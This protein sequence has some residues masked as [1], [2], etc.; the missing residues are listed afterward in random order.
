M[1]L[2]HRISSRLRFLSYRREWG[3]STPSTGSES[4]TKHRSLFRLYRE[5]FQ[6]LEGHWLT[7]VFALIM[8]SVATLLKLVPPAATKLVIDNVLLGKPL[9]SGL[10]SRLHLPGTPKGRLIALVISVLVISVVGSVVSLWG[11]WRATL[12][13]KK[14]QV[15]VRRRVFDHA[16]RLPLHR[17]YQLKSGGVASLLREDAGGVG[18]LIF[19][20]I[21][22]PWRA[23]VQLVGGLIILLWVDWRLLS[24]A[25]LL[26]PL[27]Y[28]GNR[29]WNRRLRPLYRD[30]RKQRQDIDAQATE[31]F[32]G[33]RVVRAFGR[34]RRESARFVGEN[35]FMT[36]QELYAWQWSRGVELLWDL[37]LPASSGAL[38]LY[39]GL[40]VI[41]GRLTLG[42]L[43]MFL[44][45]L[46]MLLEPLAVLA[47]SVTQLQS[48]LSG[49][50]RV[51]D[52]LAEPREMPAHEGSLK[53]SKRVVQ[54]RVTFEGVDFAY[55]KTD[56]MVLRNINIDVE[57]GE[58]IAL[59]GR[60]GSGKT[61][62]CNLIARFYD[63]VA[64]VVRLDG[65]DLRDIDVESY[66]RLFGI[67][68][69][70]VFLFDGTVAENIAYADRR[71]T[72]ARVE[73][74]ARVANV[75]EFIE[76]L[77][78]GYDTRIGERGFRLSGGQR[79][80]LAIARAILADPP[81]FILDE[82]TS[83]LDSH[84]ERLIQEALAT[85]LQGRTSFVIAH[86]LST[87]RSADRIFVL[88]N[89]AIVETGTHAELMAESLRYRE[90][91]ELQRLEHGD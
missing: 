54:G 8:L 23:L 76:R 78:D 30:A 66:R 84:S 59:V 7:I 85:L 38:M 41:D 57:P 55:P 70:D 90:M 19:S 17:V 81:I 58:V 10:D 15:A 86:R 75:A 68:E 26:G 65:Q 61:T 71:A 62:L 77:P 72:R 31:A 46:T 9:P 67:V 28:L 24:A 18:E 74:A 89:G 11:R 56:A 36:R 73:E 82:A 20:M 29:L 49:F 42:D 45:Y 33:M 39:G 3:R 88:E 16:V 79:Q 80:R 83:N 47:T 63:P 60:S 52:L 51:L 64:G 4:T 43:M 6:F 40:R 1:S 35:H 53:I 44:V 69:Q 87:I 2:Q 5:L 22:N 34:Q 12:A 13:S 48:N 14:V 27:V 32:G 25:A 50:D 37:L 91:V 21:Y